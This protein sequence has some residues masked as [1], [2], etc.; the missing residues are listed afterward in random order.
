VNY[1][2]DHHDW[3]PAVYGLRQH[4]SLMQTIGSAA[5]SEGRLVT[6]P[7]AIQHQ[8]QPFKLVDPTKAGYRKILALFLVDPN[9]NVIS[10]ADVPCQRA[11][12]C[13]AWGGEGFPLTMEQAKEYRELLMEERKRFVLE[14]QSRT[15]VEGTISL[16]EH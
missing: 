4:G 10:T 6:F 13:E 14:H 1:P 11:D 3:L 16:C 15:D 9:V 12:W 7:N 5:T 8:V 2:P